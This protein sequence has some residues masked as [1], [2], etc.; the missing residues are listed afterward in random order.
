MKKAKREGLEVRGW[1]IGT[2]AEFLGLTI[3]ES[4]LIEVKL[5]LPKQPTRAPDEAD[6][7]SA[8]G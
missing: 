4:A 2:V 1:K 6:D 8:T 7:S 5:A 3:E